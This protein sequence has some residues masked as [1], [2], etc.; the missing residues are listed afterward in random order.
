MTAPFAS[1]MDA[2][3]GLLEERARYEAWL[4]RLD[5]HRG[6][7][8]GHVLERVRGDYEERL[9]GVIAQLRGRASELDASATA[10]AHCRIARRGDGTA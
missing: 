5:E 9:N 7:T 3:A 6:S 10:M 4:N 1:P 2:L 8:P